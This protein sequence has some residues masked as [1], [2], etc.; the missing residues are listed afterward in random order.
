[1][2]RFLI[3]STLTLTLATAGG[4]FAMA[5]NTHLLPNHAKAEAQAL[6][7][8]ASFDNLTAAQAGAIAATLYGDDSN[9]GGQIR[10]ILNWN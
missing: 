2:K 3:A 9:R 10:S 7:P 4:A 6:V 1:M 5:T 8:N